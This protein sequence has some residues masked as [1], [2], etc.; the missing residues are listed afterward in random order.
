MTGFRQTGLKSLERDEIFLKCLCENRDKFSACADHDFRKLIRVGVAGLQCDLDE[1]VGSFAD[2]LL[3]A[4]PWG[5]PGA[6]V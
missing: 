5:N 4:R 6:A 3:G 2:E 1:A